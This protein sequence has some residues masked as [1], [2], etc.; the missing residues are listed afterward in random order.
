MHPKV[1]W[2]ALVAVLATAGIGAAE[3][4]GHPLPPWLAGVIVTVVG[5]ITGYSVSSPSPTPLVTTG[6]PLDSHTNAPMRSAEE[7]QS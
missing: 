7:P 1:K 4:M 6:A 2:T 5:S 3:A